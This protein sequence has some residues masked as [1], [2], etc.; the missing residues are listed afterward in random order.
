MKAPLRYI[1][2]I[3]LVAVFSMK[4]ALGEPLPG[5]IEHIIDPRGPAIDRIA[6]L[7]VEQGNFHYDLDSMNYSGPNK[8]IDV[9]KKT[10]REAVNAENSVLL[11]AVRTDGSE[12]IVGF[13]LG[14]HR[15]LEDHRVS[16]VLE[17]FIDEAYRRQGYGTH[18]LNTFESLG[19]AA[20]SIDIR[21]NVH[22]GNDLAK[23]FYEHWGFVEQ[24]FHPQRPFERLMQKSFL[25]MR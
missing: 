7:Y 22:V 19:R 5:R 10:L 17:L 16:E 2:A 11:V 1:V 13:L 14:E 25:D 21:L 23:Q 15:Q 12:D 24:G 3:G 6:E 8:S 4:L 9:R 18:L 20:G